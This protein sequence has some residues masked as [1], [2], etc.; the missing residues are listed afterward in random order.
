MSINSYKVKLAFRDKRGGY[1]GGVVQWKDG[2]VGMLSGP[3]PTIKSIEEMAITDAIIVVDRTG[4]KISHP[5]EYRNTSE[6]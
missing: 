4:A 3:M 1:V 2:S 5:C 6:D